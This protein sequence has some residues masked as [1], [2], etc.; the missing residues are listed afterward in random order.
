[1]ALLRVPPAYPDRLGSGGA[2]RGKRPPGREVSVGRSRTGYRDM[3][4]VA[5]N[6][7]LR[8]KLAH[9]S[10][11]VA[12]GGRNAAPRTSDEWKYRGKQYSVVQRLDTMWKW[13][14]P[15]LVGQT[16]S[17]RAENHT[18]GVKAAQRAIDKALAPGKQNLDPLGPRGR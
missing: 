16:K 10:D 8:I 9:V 11:S 14:V 7:S 6:L 5:R 4:G 2:V 15:G 18:A 1:M 12:P 3:M 13:S 17:G